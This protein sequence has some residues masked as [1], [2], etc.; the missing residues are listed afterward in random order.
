MAKKETM[1]RADALT[2]LY[3]VLQDQHKAIVD[4]QLLIINLLK[5]V[6]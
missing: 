3:L 4:N 1:S 5:E 6:K 2:K